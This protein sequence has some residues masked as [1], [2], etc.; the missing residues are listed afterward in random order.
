MLA[1]LQPGKAIILED[2]MFNLFPDEIPRVEL[3]AVN[4]FPDGGQETVSLV[5]GVQGVIIPAGESPMP[6]SLPRQVNVV[7]ARRGLALPAAQ[8][9]PLEFAP[10]NRA[11]LQGS[12]VPFHAQ[13]AITVY[14]TVQV[15]KHL[16]VFSS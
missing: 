14:R 13:L 6:F 1:T 7:T 8:G 4:T 10:A 15:G 9:F 2:K 5:P 16:W 11:F 12:D 3:A